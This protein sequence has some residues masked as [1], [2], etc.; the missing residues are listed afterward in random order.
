[1]ADWMWIKVMTGKV[2][3]PLVADIVHRESFEKQLPGRHDIGNDAKVLIGFWLAAGTWD[4]FVSAKLWGVTPGPA[5]TNA[6]MTLN[7]TQNDFWPEGMGSQAVLGDSLAPIGAMLH[8]RSAHAVLVKLSVEGWGYPGF[9]D[10]VLVGAA[11]VV[12]K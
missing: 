10:E 11:A 7:A 12:D 1:M 8:V 5:Y 9:L 4:V 2:H 3:R 6:T